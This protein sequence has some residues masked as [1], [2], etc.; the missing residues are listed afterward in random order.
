ML[1]INA[2]SIFTWENR[3]EEKISA[4]TFDTKVPFVFKFTNGVNRVIIDK[5]KSSCECTVSELK[6]KTYEPGEKGEIEGYLS[7]GEIART[8]IITLA[9]IG[10]YQNKNGEMIEFIDTLRLNGEITSPISVKPGILLWRK[11]A[12]AKEKFAEIKLGEMKE[13]AYSISNRGE[14]KGFKVRLEKSPDFNGYIIFAE[15][16]STHSSSTQRVMIKQIYS[17]GV[18]ERSQKQIYIHLIIR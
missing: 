6:K 11:G 9:V 3:G 2:S 16:D 13:I 10:R 7:T 15:P 18:T 14:I 4:E 12:S 5:I 17:H 8:T 1:L